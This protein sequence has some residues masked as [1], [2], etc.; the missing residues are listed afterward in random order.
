MEEKE[1]KKKDLP[2][3]KLLANI[4]EKFLLLMTIQ[5]MKILQKI[6]N[7]IIK[8]CKKIA[9]DIGSRKKAIKTAIQELSSNEILLVAGKGMKKFKTM[10]TKL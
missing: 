7:S 1:I 2:W 5:E 9:V 6:R 4:V 8:G 10:V 3:V